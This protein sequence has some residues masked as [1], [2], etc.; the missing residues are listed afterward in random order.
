MKFIADKA[1][2]YVKEAFSSLGE[3]HLLPAKEI[4]ASALQDAVGLLVRT[5]TKITPS[6]L[7]GSAV[8]FI[9]TATIGTDHIDLPYLAEQQIH[10]S[11]APGCNAVAVAEYILTA[12]LTLEQKKGLSTRSR[13]LGIIGAGNTGL[14]LKRKA[15]AIGIQCLLND[16]PL[17]ENPSDTCFSHLDEIIQIADIIS[18]HVPL[19]HTGNHPT[20]H[21]IDEHI[22]RRLKP[23]TII[24][25]TSRGETIDGQALK[26]NRKRLGA[27]ILDVW[28]H[29]PN[30]DPTLLNEVDIATPHIAGY[31]LEGKVRAT[32]M[33]YRDACN[34]FE[35]AATWKASDALA[36]YGLP[37]LTLQSAGQLPEKAVLQTYNIWED[38]S[39]LRLFPEQDNS[40]EYFADLRNNY[41]FRREFSSFKFKIGQELSGQD[42]QLLTAIGFKIPN[43]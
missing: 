18:L 25:N 29:E 24:I 14:A 23:G 12:L 6:L 35:T 34:F 30:I 33:I 10:L 15:E 5:T 9:G 39:R 41:R 40:G 27:I 20:F 3:V 7:N 38:D 26:N 32:E 8:K 22:L 36:P 28:E 19:T 1:I 17:A 13:T 2:P 21:L 43:K 42:H 16:P 11:S 4:T 37:E 31:S